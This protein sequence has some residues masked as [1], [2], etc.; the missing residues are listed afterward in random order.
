MQQDENQ[1]NLL[2]AIVLSVLV[3]LGWQIFFVNPKIK[4]EQ[5]RK[6]QQQVQ[7]V[8]VQPGQT[9]SVPGAAPRRRPHPVACR[10]WRCRCPSSPCRARM[11]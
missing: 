6:A 9:P 10:R 3:L 4:D 11:P 8:P 2:L 5:A 7:Q 1:K